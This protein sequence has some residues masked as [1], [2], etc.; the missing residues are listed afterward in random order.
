MYYFKIYYPKS[1]LLTPTPLTIELAKLDVSTR[2]DLLLNISTDLTYLISD[3]VVSGRSK[4]LKEDV[5]LPSEIFFSSKL[6]NF[7]LHKFKVNISFIHYVQW[8][9][10]N[11]GL[12][13]VKSFVNQAFSED[14][15]PLLLHRYVEVIL[16]LETPNDI[17]KVEF[18]LESTKNS[19]YRT[20]FLLENLDSGIIESI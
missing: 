11:E 15:S 18:K 16:H 19:F 7:L 4:L 9:Y 20:V 8:A 17:T 2:D 14:I 5:V 6:G 13:N 1:F 3:L 12:E 10:E